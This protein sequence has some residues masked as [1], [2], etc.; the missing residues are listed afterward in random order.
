M[1]QRRLIIGYLFIM[2]WCIVSWKS[3][4]QNILAL[5]TIETNY[6]AAIGAT[7]EALWLKGLVSKLEMN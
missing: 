7:K 3:T 6:V 1:D 2:C 5:S 4:L